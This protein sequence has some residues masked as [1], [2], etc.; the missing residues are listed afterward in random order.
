MID[1]ATVRQSSLPKVIVKCDGIKKLVLDKTNIPL[2]NK[3]KK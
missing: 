2:N 3:K 1:K